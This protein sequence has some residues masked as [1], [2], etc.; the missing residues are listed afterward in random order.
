MRYML[1]ICTDPDGEPYSPEKDDIAEWVA[2]NTRRGISLHGD[3][4]RDVEDATTV[5]V[6]RGETLVTDGPFAETR[7]RIAGYDVIEVRS[8]DEAIEVASRHPM[9]RFGRVEVRP[10]WPLDLDAPS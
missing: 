3:R 9:A 1:F 2:E 5:R 6:R 7:E 4:L 8:L 10:V